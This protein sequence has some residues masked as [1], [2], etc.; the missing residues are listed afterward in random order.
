MENLGK[1]HGLFQSFEQPDEEAVN[2]Y[3]DPEMRR[4]PL[5][6]SPALLFVRKAVREFKQEKISLEEFL[7]RI[8]KL[9]AKAV[10]QLASFQTSVKDALPR[11]DADGKTL[12]G[13]L[14]GAL[15]KI[16]EGCNT[17]LEFE[18]HA[19]PDSL[20]EGLAQIEEGFL[21]LDEAEEVADER[22]E[23][24]P[25]ARSDDDVVG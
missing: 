20:D 13:A 8:E 2:Y 11:A 22:T 6:Q 23:A 12:A 25:D 24:A 10:Q 9:E 15:G 1:I 7:T 5:D 17:L 21:E 14:Q 4:V 19:E 3:V 16:L 18:D